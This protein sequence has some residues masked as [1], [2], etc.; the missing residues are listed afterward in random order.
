[1]IGIGALLLRLFGSVVIPFQI[2]RAISNPPASPA[3]AIPQTLSAESRRARQVKGLLSAASSRRVA[4]VCIDIPVS[5][6][7]NNYILCFLHETLVKYLT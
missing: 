3:A 7:K 4:I 1:M 2:E 6:R 5:Y